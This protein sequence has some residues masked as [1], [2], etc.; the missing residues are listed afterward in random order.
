MTPRP[1]AG[2]PLRV[3]LAPMYET[4]GGHRCGR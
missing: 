3:G 4:Q 2:T 1:T